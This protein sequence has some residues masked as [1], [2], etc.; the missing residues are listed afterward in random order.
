[1]IGAIAALAAAGA[2]LP[3]VAQ[4]DQPTN[5]CLGKDGATPD[6]QVNGC[7][8][9]IAAGK[10]SGAA[11]AFAFANRCKAYADLKD[12]DKALADCNQAIQLDPNYA[13][14]FN[15][16]GFVWRSRRDLDRALA[17]YS[18]AI[19]LDPRDPFTLNNRGVVLAARKSYDP[20]I[21]DYSEAIRL[22]AH[23]DELRRVP[24]YR[25]RA[26]A[27][28][29]KK[30]F[31]RA[32][33]DFD[34]VTRL[35]PTDAAIW[36]ARCWA[37]AVL[38]NDLDQAIADCVEALLLAPNDP[39][40]LDSRGF[41]NLKS[42]DLDAAIADYDAA[43]ARNPKLA[44]SLYGRGFAKTAKGNTDGGNADIAAAKAIQADIADEMA[45]YGLK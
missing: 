3:A 30:D 22:S 31:A 10:Y 16:R 11:L 43:L 12:T 28:Q 15:N 7:T 2:T 5:W 32:L 34:R 38:G 20:A 8:A 37:R 33:P 29:A 36:N 13:V 44:G 41:A 1:M 27:Y 4:T 14:A 17:D 9:V 25:N 6:Q 18:A 35:A 21:A 26:L 23:L 24:F 39:A 40:A 19:R 45:G 42:G